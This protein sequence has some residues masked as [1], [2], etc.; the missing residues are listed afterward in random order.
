[1]YLKLKNAKNLIAFLNKFGK[2]THVFNHKAML[3]IRKEYVTFSTMIGP[4][5][6][7]FN[8][9]IIEKKDVETDKLCIGFDTFGNAVKQD[10]LEIQKDDTDA[11]YFND[12]FVYTYDD[13]I[14]SDIYKD[15][16]SQEI[17]TIISKTDFNLLKKRAPFINKENYELN[18]FQI[19][20]NKLY[21][22][23]AYVLVIDDLSLSESIP[24]EKALFIP[25]EISDLVPF[26]RD[27]LIKIIEYN[28][29]YTNSLGETTTSQYIGIKDSNLELLYTRGEYKRTTIYEFLERLKVNGVQISDEK[30][31]DIDVEVL[32]RISKDKMAFRVV[33]K[34]DNE[35]I[36]VEDSYTKYIMKYKNYSGE[37]LGLSKSVIIPLVK[38]AKERKKDKLTIYCD[39]AKKYGW[40]KNSNSKMMLYVIHQEE[41]DEE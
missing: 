30:A 24:L 34:P 5:I 7:N 23:N 17:L 29:E 28:Y 15:F 4:F 26:F 33:F 41:I 21:C 14:L 32:E 22:S 35:G 11:I 27:S 13:E 18:R 8:L 39:V 9:P 2:K 38:W 3:F 10:I 12:T 1:M 40:V 6:V 25:Y 36:T 16:N 19:V 37:R 31:L 20:H